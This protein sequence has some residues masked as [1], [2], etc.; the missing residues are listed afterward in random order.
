M[1]LNTLALPV[2]SEKVHTRHGVPSSGTGMAQ[3]FPFPNSGR[4]TEEEVEAMRTRKMSREPQAGKELS[5]ESSEDKSPQQNLVGEAVCSGST[6][7]ECNGEEKPRRSRTRRGCKRRSRGSQQE[8]PG[9]ARGGDH[10]SELGVH[11]QDHDG[12][13]PHKCSECGKS[14]RWRSR[15]IQHGTIHME[16]RPYECDKCRKRF[17]TK[18]SLLKHYG[19]HTE[20]RPYECPDCGKGFKRNPHL[21]R[22]RLIHTGERPHECEE[23]GKSFRRSSYLIV[24][25]RI[26]NGERPYKCGECGKSF[27]V[28]SNL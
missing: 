28:S 18:S 24:H 6:A 8:R 14:F 27:I 20:E 16:E 3:D 9:L 25:Q 21:V 1:S 12:E 23:C 13:K 19:S 15:L 10:S 11:E 26:H 2:R 7:Q 4:V 5:P 17:Q 22:H